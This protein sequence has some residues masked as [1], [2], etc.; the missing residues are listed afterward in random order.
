[1]YRRCE[2]DGCERPHYGRGFCNLHYQ[3]AAKFGDPGGAESRK[4]PRRGSCSL[5]D[6]DNPILSRGLCRLHYERLRRT[7]TTDPPIRRRA[8]RQRRVCGVAGCSRKHEAK[9]LCSGH[10][11]RWKKTGDVGDAVLGSRGRAPTIIR[12]GYHF[13]YVPDHPNANGQGYVL[14]HRLVMADHLGR[15]LLPSEEVHHR[16]GIRDDNRLE[17]LELWLG[18]HPPGQRVA[19]LLPWAREIVERYDGMLFP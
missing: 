1:M 18:S 17:N 2:V 12:R 4:V 8:A 19:D 7:G 15:A 14:T 11:E 13:T 6:C 5:D 3:R 16:N 10:Y 9:G